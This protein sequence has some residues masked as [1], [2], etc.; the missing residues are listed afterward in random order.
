MA[1][2]VVLKS[3]WDDRGVKNALG[4]FSKFGKGVGVAFAAVGAATA[5]ATAA[6]VKFGSDSIAAAE[7]VQQANNRLG[8]V[9]KSMNLF[10]AQTGAVTQRIIEFAEANELSVG[11]DAEVIKAAQAKLLT[12]KNLAQTANVMGGEFDR[13]TMAALDLAA[14]GF[15]SAETNATQLGKALQDPIKG[16]T[17]L[18]RSGVTFTQEERNKIKVLVESGKTLEAQ[19]MILSA[20]ETQVGGTAEA[21]AKA[22]DRMK[23]AFD[24]VSE[25]VGAALLPTFELFADEV[26]KL[27]PELEKALAPAA[28]EVAKIFKDQVLP[29]IQDFTKWL[30]SPQGTQT[31]K[32][33]V[34]AVVDAIKNFIDFIFWVNENKD[35]LMILAGAIAGLVI[36]YKTITTATALW[37]AAIVLTTTKINLAT[38]AT[39]ALSTATKLLPWAAL[40]TAGAF[41]VATLSDYAD[42]VYGSKIN[43]E[44]LTESQIKEQRQLESLRRQL[45]QY[46]YA[47]KNATEGNKKLAEDGI[48]K[49]RNEILILETRIKGATGEMARFN[50]IKLNNLRKEIAASSGEMNRFRNL[51]QGF[52][53]EYNP[54]LEITTS[55][56]NTGAEVEKAFDKV[57]KFIKSA[58][59][60]LAQAQE[61]YNKT[62]AT[63][64]KRYA[65]AVIKTQAD[66]TKKLEDIIQ[67]SQDRLRNVFRQAA[68]FTFNDFL[69]EFNRSEDKRLEAFYQAQE[70][71]KKTN[72]AFTDSFVGTDPVTA[73][74]KSLEDKV[75]DNRRLLALSAKLFE[76]GFSQVF[77]EQM[78]SSG[79]E[80]GDAVAQGL[81]DSSPETLRRIQGLFNE[82]NQQAETGMDGLAREIYDKAGFATRELAGL[83]KTTQTQLSEALK[84]LQDQFNQEVVDANLTLIDSIKGIREAF[85]ENIDSMKGDLGGL[86][87]VVDEFMRKL[88]QVETDAKNRVENVTG[89]TPGATGTTGGAM[90]GVVTA[91]SAVT[92]ATGIFIDSMNDVGRVIA[93][94]QERITAANTFAN[95]AAIAGRTTEAMSAVNLRNEFRSQLGLIQSLG[96]GAVGTTIN[97]NVK[98]DSTQSLAMVGKTLGNTITKY[99]SAGGQVLVSPTN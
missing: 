80:G 22:S 29:A 15:G 56:T 10:G 44:G 65:D 27:T 54:A 66:F 91:A 31:I 17:A 97:I 6:L 79:A 59:K 5:A 19:N 84:E 43:T 49:T 41:A 85:K 3:V 4:E 71:A 9:A 70:E 26:V 74:I 45:G 75:N 98:T 35:A 89:P 14:A 13:A 7:N 40:I 51:A 94:L 2:N 69:T 48:K 96:T 68:S 46:E 42:A 23:L 24:N 39:T 25:A 64:Q 30:A 57:Q 62:I 67:Q 12:F 63:A 36:S 16:I 88:G 47:L 33:L 37:Q 81:L 90:S 11:V 93:Y 77:I 38:G 83:Y 72:K 34:Q 21:T 32:N 87:K 99:V 1:V 78:L 60:D 28:E 82:I 73:L 8:A 92:N 55:T 20:I 61:Q 95:E 58:Q 86:G 18:T 50:N 52:V 76:A 53:A